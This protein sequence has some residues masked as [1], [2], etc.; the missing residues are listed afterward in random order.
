MRVLQLSFILAACNSDI[1]TNGITRNLAH[2][3]KSLMGLYTKWNME[4]YNNVMIKNVVKLCQ[5]QAHHAVLEVG[6]GPGLGLQEA[7][8]YL[9]DPRGKLFGLD[10]SEYMHKVSRERLGPQL[11]SGRVHLLQGRVECIP[12]PDHCIDGVFH[13]N[14]HLYW[15]DMATATA[16]LL[17]IMR[18]GGKMLST[19]DLGFLRHGVEHGFFKGKTVEPEPYLQALRSFG[20]LRVSMKDLMDEGKSFQVIYTTSPPPSTTETQTS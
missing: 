14:C 12:L 5:I 17:R 20:F 13:S 7:L 6:F 15:P 4:K 1:F 11:V 9:T 8:K 2:P 18:P 16:E 19:C 10:I 3:K